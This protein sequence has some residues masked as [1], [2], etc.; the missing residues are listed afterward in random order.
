MT[1]ATT[2]QPYVNGSQARALI[3]AE[4]AYKRAK[5]EFEEQKR[6]RAKVRARYAHLFPVGEVVEIAGYRFRRFMA[7]TGVSFRLAEYLKHH[8]VTAAMEPHVGEDSEYEDWSVT[9]IRRISLP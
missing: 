2:G 4:L 8:E 1:T 5:D 3:K 7:R 6:Q 9:P